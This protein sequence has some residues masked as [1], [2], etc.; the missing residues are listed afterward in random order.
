MSKVPHRTRPDMNWVIVDDV[1]SLAPYIIPFNL[2]R[3]VP[4]D[5]KLTPVGKGGIGGTGALE[6]LRQR[7]E[8]VMRMP[9]N[10]TEQVTYYT[11]LEP[12]EWKEMRHEL[13]KPLTTA[14]LSNVRHRLNRDNWFENYCRREFFPSALTFLMTNSAFI[15]ADTFWPIRL[16]ADDKWALLIAENV[17]PTYQFQRRKH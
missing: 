2:G 16:G 11:V 7:Q 6:M 9:S 17:P 12:D 15:G 13:T 8:E 10:N 14:V 4:L 3:L 5:E 1:E